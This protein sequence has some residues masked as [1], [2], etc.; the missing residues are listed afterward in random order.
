MNTIIIYLI[1]NLLGLNINLNR[2]YQQL[3]TEIGSVSVQT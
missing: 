1:L 2:E 3:F